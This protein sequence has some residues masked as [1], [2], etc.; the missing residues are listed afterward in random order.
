[1][2]VISQS[3]SGGGYTGL[4]VG[5]LGV[6]GTL[7]V[8]KHP[9]PTNIRAL[10]NNVKPCI[11]CMVRSSMRRH[12]WFDPAS[13]AGVGAERRR[14]REVNM[15]GRAGARRQGCRCD[16]WASCMGRTPGGGT[17]GQATPLARGRSRTGG[18]HP[19][20]FAPGLIWT[21]GKVDR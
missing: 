3:G 5:G 7:F 20:R 2:E 6:A 11:P 19:G 18:A 17:Y 13:V 4:G 8:G 9:A 1:M 12:R 15:R 10:I 16:E 14:R 21:L